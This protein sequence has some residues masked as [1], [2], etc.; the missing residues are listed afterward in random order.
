MSLQQAMP[1]RAK[2]MME[3]T[4]ALARV[5]E[6]HGV[7]V[8]RPRPLTDMEIAASPLGLFNQYRP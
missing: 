1:E 6:D 8:H 2:G 4:E 7:I 3:Q 5:L